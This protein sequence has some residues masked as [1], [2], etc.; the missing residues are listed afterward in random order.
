MAAVLSDS[1]Q[2]LALWC[3]SVSYI[4]E[5]TERVVVGA[6]KDAKHPLFRTH[7]RKTLRDMQDL[8]LIWLYV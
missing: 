5:E 4:I 2:N 7:S 6:Q 8:L 3:D 1:A